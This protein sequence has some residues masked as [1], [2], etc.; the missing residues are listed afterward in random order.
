MYDVGEFPV[1]IRVVACLITKGTLL[2][3]DSQVLIPLLGYL[4]MSSDKAM[5]IM[6]FCKRHPFENAIMFM[7]IFSSSFPFRYR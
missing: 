4:F 3:M 6:H 2:E 7:F 5:I 1:V